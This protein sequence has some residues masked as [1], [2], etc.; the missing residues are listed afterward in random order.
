MITLLL[1]K[2][3][4]KAWKVIIFSYVIVIWSFFKNPISSVKLA[5]YTRTISHSTQST[6]S[7][8]ALDTS[9]TNTKFSTTITRGHP[10]SMVT[11][12]CEVIALVT[13]SGGSR[14]RGGGEECCLQWR[15]GQAI[16]GSEEMWD[17]WYPSPAHAELNPLWLPPTSWRLPSTRPSTARMS[18]NTCDASTIF[19]SPTWPPAT[20]LAP[21][22]EI[23]SPF[24]F[25][26]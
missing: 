14:R 25:L 16:G 8:A 2:R 5:D 11:E 15:V 24:L 3:K 9:H 21:S 6:S 4:N 10:H 13:E 26:G 7:L 22:H 1:E 12:S 17:W 19:T 23:M 20:V 18:A